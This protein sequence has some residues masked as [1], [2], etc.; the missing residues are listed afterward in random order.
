MADEKTIKELGML[1]EG[2]E[3]IQNDPILKPLL[4]YTKAALIFEDED[5][6][7]NQYLM[8]KI[9]NLNKLIETGIYGESMIAQKYEEVFEVYKRLLFIYTRYAKMADEKMGDVKKI[10]R[11][12]YLPIK[13]GKTI[14]EPEK[15]EKKEEK[16][17]PTKNLK[18]MEK[19][20]F[21]MNHPKEINESDE[22]KEKL[23]RGRP[24]KVISEKE[25][26]EGLEELKKSLKGFKK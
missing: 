19:Q 15:I 4:D 5:K 17:I 10:V 20:A 7:E 3:D 13:D 21:E 24:K 6:S 14:K 26:D 8:E 11:R 22:L 12:Y 18:E 2:I 9:K 16:I 25:E 1:P 23:K